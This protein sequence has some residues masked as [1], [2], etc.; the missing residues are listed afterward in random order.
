MLEVTPEVAHQLQSLGGFDILG[1]L[2]RMDGGFNDRDVP[3]AD[4]SDLLRQALGEI[5]SLGLK[6]TVATDALCLARTR[7][8][9]ACFVDAITSRRAHVLKYYNFLGG[10]ETTK[11]WQT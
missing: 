5:L 9:D 11:K 7:K 8:L 4:Q 3:V 10:S 6:Y 2:P 1:I